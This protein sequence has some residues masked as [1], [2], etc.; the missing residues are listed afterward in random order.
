MS[1]LLDALNRA[2]QERKRNEATP[3]IDSN[4]EQRVDDE[5]RQ[6]PILLI[7]AIVIGLF[8]LAALVYWLGQR[9]ATPTATTATNSTSSAVK[10]TV[11]NNA[12]KKVPSN[13][14]KTVEVTEPTP[15][16]ENAPVP[17]ESVTNLYQ[18]TQV[19]DT[20]TAITI[21]TPQ[22]E[23]EQTPDAAPPAAP[24]ST[25]PIS[26]AQYTNMPELHNLPKDMLEKVPTLTYSEHHYDGDNSNV[27]INGHIFHVNDQIANG[28]V[29]DR[30][31]EDGMILNIE[32]H[33]FK[34][35][36][37]NSWINM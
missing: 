21:S 19:P 6:K 17:D 36:A 4:H 14:E 34:M 33:P 23:P 35:R 18:Q 8:I 30:I 26:I 5:P 10:N 12:A 22:Q 27:K 32:N 37:M 20:N 9:S 24:T 15:E 11:A 29:I 25:N 13:I 28:I 16:V 7:T 31:L 1:L 2:D 3:G